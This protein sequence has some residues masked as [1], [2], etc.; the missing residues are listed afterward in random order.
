MRLLTGHRR[1]ATNRHCPGCGASLRLPRLAGHRGGGIPR[2]RHHAQ[3][4]PGY[5]SGIAAG[6]TLEALTGGVPVLI[7]TSFNTAGKPIVCSPRDAPE[8]FWTS[9]LDALVMG[10]FLLTKP[11]RAA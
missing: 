5:A 11:Q 1:V 7:N 10:P 2:Q 6:N 9:A 4:E 3:Q 8:A